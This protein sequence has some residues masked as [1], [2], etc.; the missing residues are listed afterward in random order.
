VERVNEEYSRF[1]GRVLVEK[2]E[3]M[4]AVDRAEADMRMRL[5]VVLDKQLIPW[6]LRKGNTVYITRGI[7]NELERVVGGIGDLKSLAELL[8]WGYDRKSIKLGKKVMNN[9]FVIVDLEE[10]VEFLS[11]DL[12]A[13]TE[14]T[15]GT[16]S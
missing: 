3:G 15:E 11:P 5:E 8:G 12:G 1:V 7:V 13:G 14:G 2:P 9:Y 16:G 6:L 10:L 4:E